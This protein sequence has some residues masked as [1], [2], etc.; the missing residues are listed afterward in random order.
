LV[1]F[2][3]PENDLSEEMVTFLE[4]LDTGTPIEP[5]CIKLG[6]SSVLDDIAEFSLFGYT[7]A[8]EALP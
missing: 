6:V 8:S 3:D 4:D 7:R 2:T 5:G 1:W